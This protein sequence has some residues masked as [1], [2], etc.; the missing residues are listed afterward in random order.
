MCSITLI[1][2]ISTSYN[3]SKLVPSNLCR[4]L[5]D[6]SQYCRY[7]L[8]YGRAFGFSVQFSVKTEKT[9]NRIMTIIKTEPKPISVGNRTEITEKTEIYLFY[10]KFNFLFIFNI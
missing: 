9:E 4:F 2:G 8:N 6:S 5:Y 10:I 7:H 3:E 1:N